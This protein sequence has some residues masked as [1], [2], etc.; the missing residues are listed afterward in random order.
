M[1]V[2][3]IDGTGIFKIYKTRFTIINNRIVRYNANH[4]KFPFKTLLKSEI[5][6][7]IIKSVKKDI[8]N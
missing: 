6:N 1:A 5:I 7:P 2:L 3:N 8:I 4:K